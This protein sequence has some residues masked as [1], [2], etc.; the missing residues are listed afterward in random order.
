MNTSTR[1]G[2]IGTLAAACIGMVALSGGAAVP[3]Q[4]ATQ[5]AVEPSA[6]VEPYSDDNMYINVVCNS[7]GTASWV[8]TY[9]I[10]APN[11]Q[12]SVYADYRYESG[13]FDG[14]G[15][16]SVEPLAA[17][18]EI[19]EPLAATY[20][21]VM[22]TG[23]KGIGSTSTTFGFASPDINRV[24]VTVTINGYTQEGWDDC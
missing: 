15:S 10:G 14:G 20:H 16:F 21:G 11:T 6:I 8:A 3:A 9:N 19:V 5:T 12:Y 1:T 2:R 23:E 13:G 7:D 17:P 18:D 4:A 22:T 24:Y